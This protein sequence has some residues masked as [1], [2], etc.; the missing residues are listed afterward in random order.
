MHLKL[1]PDLDLAEA[2]AVAERVEAELLRAPGIDAVQTHLEPLERPVA[3]RPAG[4]RDADED[5]EQRRIRAIVAD[6]TGG[7]PCELR[8]L[9]SDAGLVVFL[10]ISVGASTSLTAAHEL[11]GR[12]EE[13]IRRGAGHIADV[14]VHTEP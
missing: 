7:R 3:A 8:L 9:R 12:L 1:P 11:A 5:D 4:G 13:D 6:D 2:H 14:V 10:T